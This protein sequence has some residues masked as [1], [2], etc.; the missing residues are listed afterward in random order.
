MNILVERHVEP[1]ARSGGQAGVTIAALAAQQ[2]SWQ[3]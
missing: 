2:T 1:A 3:L